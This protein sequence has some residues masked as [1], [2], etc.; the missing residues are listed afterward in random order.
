MLGNRASSRRAG[1][2][3]CQNSFFLSK[4]YLKKRVSSVEWKSL[5]LLEKLNAIASLKS[6]K[7]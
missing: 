6:T 1:S 4:Q 7:L 2:G 3:G 5:Y